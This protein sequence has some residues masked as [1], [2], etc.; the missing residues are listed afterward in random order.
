[1][2]NKN[3]LTASLV[4]ASFAG[5][6]QGNRAYAITGDG[7]SDFTWMNIRQVDLATGQVTKTLFERS[8]TNY[9]MTDVNSN[10]TVDQRS[11]TNG[12]IFNN[13][14]YP[15]GTYV[16]AAAYD[17]KSNKLFFTPMRNGELRWLELGGK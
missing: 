12:D 13:S 9:Q 1:M 15:T 2:N 4:A 11:I 6:A 17:G 8:K 5:N 10:K 7:N 16:A 3:L 14:N